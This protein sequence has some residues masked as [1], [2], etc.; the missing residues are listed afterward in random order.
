MLCSCVWG[1]ENA[2]E[3]IGL[4]VQDWHGV[5]MILET[6]CISA[7]SM[8][9]KSLNTH[10]PGNHWFIFIGWFWQSIALLMAIMSFVVRAVCDWVTAMDSNLHAYTHSLW[11]DGWHDDNGEASQHVRREYAK[12]IWMI[13]F[14]LMANSITEGS[15]VP[16]VPAWGAEGAAQ[17]QATGPPRA[18]EGWPPWTLAL[19]GHDCLGS[20]HG[21]PWKEGS[22]KNSHLNTQYMYIDF[23]KQ[24][25]LITVQS[26]KQISNQLLVNSGYLTH[27]MTLW[28]TVVNQ[29]QAKHRFSPIRI[30]DPPWFECLGG[31]SSRGNSC[32]PFLG[33]AVASSFDQ[34]DWV[35]SA[36]CNRAFLRDREIQA[37]DILGA[38][39]LTI[40]QGQPVNEPT[41]LFTIIK[42]DSNLSLNSGLSM[43]LSINQG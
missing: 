8:I 41:T 20:A 23:D 18:A 26:W 24:R 34:Q 42:L 3:S 13:M 30:R 40:N 2:G 1:R 6:R 17:S 36:R 29:K 11:T 15:P 33:S 28:P 16:Q 32:A 22:M 35:S 5:W 27:K 9:L 39:I 10:P 43:S 37:F 25:S 21:Q 38:G 31:P 7:V 12:Q 14:L 4:G 19:V